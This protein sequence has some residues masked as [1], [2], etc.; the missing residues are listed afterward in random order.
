MLTELLPKIIQ[1]NGNHKNRVTDKKL[2]IEIFSDEQSIELLTPEWK[3][4]A[5]SSHAIICL[6][7]EWITAWWK[8]FGRNCYRKL[9]IITV[10]LDNRLLALAPFYVG[11]TSLFG[12]DAAAPPS[13]H[14]KRRQ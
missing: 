14:W 10:K 9:H 2:K 12:S 13:A 8:H 3:E 6:S 11:F 7:P 5:E 4:L 1:K